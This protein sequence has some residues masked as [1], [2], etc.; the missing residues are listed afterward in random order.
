MIELKYC[1]VPHLQNEEEFNRF[2]K[3]HYIPLNPERVMEI[4]SFYGATLWAW[5]ANNKN[6]KQ[7]ISIDLPIPPSDGRYND[8]VRCRKMWLD[9]TSEIDFIDFEGDSHALETYVQVSHIVP[10]GTVDMLFIDGDHSYNGVSLDWTMYQAFVKPGGL[11]VFH[12]STGYD[13]VKKLCDEIR[14]LPDY[15][16]D[17]IYV[18]GGWGLFI[19]KKPK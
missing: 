12:D 17:E 3:E 2:I 16:T 5:I 7:L 11:I 15:Q 8:M 10:H 19:V 4:G 1:P 18:P 9:W 13:S 14:Q 6:L